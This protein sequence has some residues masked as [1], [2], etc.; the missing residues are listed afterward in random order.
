MDVASARSVSWTAFR[1]LSGCSEC[2]VHRTFVKKSFVRRGEEG[3]VIDKETLV[4]KLA[5]RAHVL[6]AGLNLDAFTC[7][8]KCHSHVRDLLGEQ[9]EQAPVASGF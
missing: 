6:R 3:G 4:P 1:E 9:T 8:R 5:E 2:V 7:Q